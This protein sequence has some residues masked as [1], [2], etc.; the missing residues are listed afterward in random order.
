MDIVSSQARPKA[1]S[2]AV[3]LLVGSAAFTGTAAILLVLTW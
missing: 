1:A 2:W 3:A